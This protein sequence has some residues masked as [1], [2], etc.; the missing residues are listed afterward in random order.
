[1][2]INNANYDQTGI[3]DNTQLGK[4]GPRVKV[5][6]GVVAH[7]SPDD[8][9]Y[10]I[11]RGDHPI[12][13]NDYVT[14]FYL[15]TRA[16][17]RVSGQ[18]DGTSPPAAGVQGRIFICTTAGG[19]FTLKGLYYDD[20][21]SWQAIVVTDGLTMVV[22][23][24]LTGGTD[25]YTGDHLYQ[26]D[27][28][29]ATWIDLGSAPALTKVVN[30]ERV[31]LDYTNVGNNTIITVPGNGTVFEVRVNVTQVFDGTTPEVKVGDGTDDD[32]LMETIHNDLEALSLYYV[33][34]DYEYGS[35]TDVILNLA[36]GGTPT[37]GQLV[38]TVFYGIAP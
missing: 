33:F 5:E 29:G 32:R 37:Q 34:N 35:P 3:S 23:T 19:G 31:T 2:P 11:T 9:G 16:D 8:T 10:V 30:F 22:T 17:V 24:D 18:I 38:A 21:A 4:G 12:G 15:E 20:G 27:A 25:E 14:K 6:S 28:T 26:W 13:P 7:R 36:I 1:M